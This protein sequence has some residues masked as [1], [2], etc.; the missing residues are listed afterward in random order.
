M[1]RDEEKV[2]LQKWRCDDSR[3]W[4]L[5]V[6]KG[7]LYVKTVKLKHP[8]YIISAES[9]DKYNCSCMCRYCHNFCELLNYA[10]KIRRFSIV[11]LAKTGGGWFLHTMYHTQH[12]PL[13]NMAT[14]LHVY[15]LPHVSTCF[16]TLP[17]PLLRQS[18]VYE[19]AVHLVRFNMK[20]GRWLY[21]CESHDKIG[22]NK[23][24]CNKPATSNGSWSWKIEPSFVALNSCKQW[25][26]DMD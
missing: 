2:K 19:K 4:Q 9:I 13:P 1:W 12:I 8:I 5:S 15:C 23:V 6:K 22:S 24:Q 3:K 25:L 7:I 16:D 26:C 11:S 21:T 17:T 18:I 20:T 14:A 10:S